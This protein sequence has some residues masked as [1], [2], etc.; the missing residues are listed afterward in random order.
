MRLLALLAALLLVAG[1]SST[2]Q[3]KPA[4]NFARSGFAACPSATGPTPSTSPLAGLKPLT[5][6]DGSED[7]FVPG[8]PTG[9]PMVINLWGSWCFPCGQEMPV[10]VDLAATAGDR[11]TV[12][13][14]DTTDSASNG[15]LAAQDKNV[16]FANVFDRNG[17]VFKALRL[18]GL[19]ATAFVTA[20]GELAYVNRGAPFTKATL[21]TA[22]AKYLGV[23]VK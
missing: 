3:P 16:K 1:C 20:K 21:T 14:V 6:M 7:T 22:L 2:A 17:K 4:P 11:V 15:V 8:A 19:P 12:L 18:K 5:C 13:G 10:F 23:K 9:R